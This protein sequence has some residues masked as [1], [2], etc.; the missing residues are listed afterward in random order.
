VYNLFDSAY[1]A[2][3]EGILRNNIRLLRMAFR[4]TDLAT[5]G[6]GNKE[7]RYMY[8]HFDSYQHD[9]GYG[10]YIAVT[11]TGGVY[12]TDKWYTFS[13][14]T[15]LAAQIPIIKSACA[16]EA[17]FLCGGERFII[18]NGF[19]GKSTVITLYDCSG[20]LVHRSMLTRKI[21]DLRRDCGVSNGVYF[22][23]L[24]RGSKGIY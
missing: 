14:P 10:I 18:P 13:T 16:A 6:G 7:L 19:A 15:S 12:T 24:K 20:R 23:R 1:N 3:P 9:P 17:T 22:V 5:N 11:G 8:D 2:E 4:Y 21:I